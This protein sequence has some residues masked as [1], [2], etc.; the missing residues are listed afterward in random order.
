MRFPMILVSTLAIAAC[1]M[2]ADAQEG[3]GT[4]RVTKQDFNIGAFEGVALAGSHD[5]VVTV[6]G[7][8]A[9]RAEGDAEII[10]KLDI[11]VENGTLRVG[12]KKGTN[13]SVGFM[14]NRAPV[15]IY[16]SMP[17]ISS[18]AVAGSGDMRVDKVEGKSFDASIAGSGD[19]EIAS[20]RVDEADFSVAGSGDIK[21]TGSAGNAKVSI[22][23]SGDVDLAG[24]QSRQANVSIVGSGGVQAQASETADISIM[25]SGDVSIAGGAKCT[26]SKR[27]SG[28]VRCG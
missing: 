25:G 13:W 17:S 24:V 11:R 1:G 8:S 27:G 26:I 12:T 28:E 22:A 14:R 2:S 20:I 19:L 15:T 9:V 21:A 16:V 10:E 23:G 18:A 6:G 4:G 7:A 3:E 5:V